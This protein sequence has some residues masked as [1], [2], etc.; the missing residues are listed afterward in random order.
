[1][2]LT[3]SHAVLYVH[4]LDSMLNFYT[5]VLGG[6]YQK[7]VGGTYH[8]TEIFD[9]NGQMDELMDALSAIEV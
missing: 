8:A 3:W 7:Y 9:F 2:N 4:N 1:M 6:E 5:N